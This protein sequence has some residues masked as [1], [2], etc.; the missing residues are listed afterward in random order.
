V[1]ERESPQTEIGGGIRHHAQHELNSLDGL[2]Y[3]RVQGKEEGE[4]RRREGEEGWRD[5]NG[6]WKRRQRR[7]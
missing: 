2:R 1:C 7:V 6:G 5:G 4:V 3:G